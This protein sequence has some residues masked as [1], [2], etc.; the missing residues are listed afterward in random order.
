M[1]GVRSG[2]QKLIKD[3]CPSVLDIGCICHLAGHTIKVGMQ[4]LPVNI[5]QLFIDDFY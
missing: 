2:M 1:K 4:S 3:E 5:D